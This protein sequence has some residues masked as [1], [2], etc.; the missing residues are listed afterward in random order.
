[1]ELRNA[2]QKRSVLMALVVV[3]ASGLVLAGGRFVAYPSFVGSP[4][5]LR[6]VV[7]KIQAPVGI[8]SHTIIFDRQVSGSVA[9]QVYAQLVAGERIPEGAIM[10][11]PL[12]PEAPYYHYDLTFSHAGVQMGAAHSDAIGCQEIEFD[13]LGGGRDHYS[14]HAA[15]G[16]S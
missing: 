2:L 10:H 14:W 3:L 15:N 16:G 9:E 7:T 8:G 4:D 1:M 11:C 13:T 5:H 6:V 12:I